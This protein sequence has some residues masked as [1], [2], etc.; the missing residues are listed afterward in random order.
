MQIKVQITIMKKT[1][2]I[3]S[4][5]LFMV[6]LTAG[7]NTRTA[8]LY[9]D[10]EGIWRRTSN[11]Q[12]VS[13]FGTNY[14]LPFAHSYRAAGYMGIDRKKAIDIDVSH[15]KRMG[16]NAFR[17]HLWD[18]EITDSIGNLLTNDHLDLLDYLI[19]RLEENGI[20]IIL[21]AQTNFGNGYPERNINTG[22][23]SYKYDKCQIHSHPDA[24]RA[25]Q[26][27]ISQLIAHKNAYTG[28]SYNADTCIVAL[29]INNEPCHAV[30]IDDTRNYINTMV[31][32]LRD[33][34]FQK[35]ILYNMSHNHD[36]VEAYLS[37]EGIGGGTFQWYPTG[38]VSGHKKTHNYLPY[39]DEYKIDFADDARFRKM[40]KVVYEFD[41]GDISASYLYPATARTFR[42]AGFQWVT[43]FAYDALFLAP[44]NTDYQT[45][46][47]NLVYTPGKAV[48]MTIASEVM[49]SVKMYQQF[50]K[51]P[52]DT[53]FNDFAISYTKDLAAMNSDE[54]F[55]YTNSND[56]TPKNLKKLKHIAGVGKSAVMQSSGNGAYFLD[57]V[58]NGTW[59]LEFFPS[60]VEIADPFAK[61]SL[62][63]KVR[64][65]IERE[66][67]ISFQLPDMGEV[68]LQLMPGKYVIRKSKK[69]FTIDTVSIFHTYEKPDNQRYMIHN[70][71]PQTINGHQLKIKINTVT[72]V[73]SALV[74]PSTISFWN[75]KNPCQ[76]LAPIDGEIGY[77]MEAEV[78]SDWLKYQIIV[79]KDGKC[80]TY[81]SEREG[82]PLDWDADDTEYYEAKVS[83]YF[84]DSKLPIRL[85]ENA[86]RDKEI[87][88]HQTPEW[89][90]IWAKTIHA[91]PLC[92]DILLIS[93]G[94]RQN[95]V[96]S[97]IYKDIR[98]MIE[99]KRDL[100][101]MEKLCVKFSPIRE[102]TLK[103]GFTDSMGFTHLATCDIAKDQE[104]VEIDLKSLKLSNT[105]FTNAI[106]P[107]FLSQEFV[108]DGNH[109][110][111]ISQIEV[112]QIVTPMSTDNF[113]FALIGAWLE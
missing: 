37:A 113:N 28:I 66:E 90:R 6:Q 19:M 1:A 88:H 55:L 9:V 98:P 26:N 104:I 56:L 18:V 8:P 70:A 53:V 85:I 13:Y 106:Y 91:L 75:D 5:L 68:S 63:R 47:L 69:E 12:E 35:T 39:V 54:K 36:F 7:Q 43:Q 109:E 3:L 71:E 102:M 61:P 14:T 46:Y 59:E 86:A 112:F 44:Y 97:V 51:Y 101:R 49:K 2:T 108:P 34:G 103:I 73:D 62:K 83:K 92:N 25:Q 110:F 40:C 4:I 67:K 57:K 79:Y 84:D 78:P 42:S 105:V 80:I 95:A 27:Y 32:T 50:P 17:L 22:G 20:D 111:D 72:A 38:L 21:T 81:P 94:G 52:A 58:K 64:T 100:A 31:K 24:I 93:G 89:A 29:E 33:N 11:N 74:Y 48:G 99:G 41:P 23:Y 16:L 96:S 30:S 87:F 10:D 76:K 77:A 60:I 65:A 45:H 107:S 15:M 82:N